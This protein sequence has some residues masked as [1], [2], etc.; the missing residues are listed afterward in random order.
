MLAA[1]GMKTRLARDVRAAVELLREDQYAT[2]VIDEA[3]VEPSDDKLDAILRH[4]GSA[5]PVF[6]NLGITGRHR[7]LKEVKAALRRAEQEQRA[8]RHNAREELTGEMSS[9]LTGLM[10]NMQQAL[11]TAVPGEAQQ[12][13]EAAYQLAD[14]LRQRLGSR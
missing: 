6:V 3:L 12:K 13:I 9:D 4:L 1:G 10:L 7:L 11:S 5:I 2:V 8:A 14:H